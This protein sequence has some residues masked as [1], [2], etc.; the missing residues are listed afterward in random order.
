[1]R[2]RFVQ[3]HLPLVDHFIV[4]SE[5]VARSL[6]G[7][8]LPARRSSSSRSNLAGAATRPGRAGSRDPRT[9]NR[10]AFFG[11]LNP[12]KGADVLLRGDGPARRATSTASVDFRREPRQA[13]A[14]VPEAVRRADR[15]PSATTSP[16]PAPTSAR[17]LAQ[18]MAGID[19]VVVPSI[20]WET[21]PIV[22][23]EAF[24]YG[25]PVIC[26]DIGGMAEKVTDG[27]NG[28]HFRRRDPEHL[29]RGACSAPPRRPASGT[30]C[31]AGIPSRPGQPDR[32][33]HV[34][35][36]TPA[37]RRTARAAPA[38]RRPGG[39]RRRRGA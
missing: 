34:E 38:P 32:G 4:P 12:Y 5:Y 10:F 7:L 39:L 1:M 36:L 35:T 18:L 9:R 8:G 27:V 33:G 30:S 2:K 24:Q 19:W 14:R 16:S 23:M 37:L 3:S 31:S 6:R 29:A 25:R 13:V 20:W 28:L 11:Q 22:V 17:D 15:A 26:S 21:G